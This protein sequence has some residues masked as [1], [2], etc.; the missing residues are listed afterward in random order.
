MSLARAL[1]VTIVLTLILGLVAYGQTIVSERLA[2]YAGKTA[3][4]TADKQ[5]N[6]YADLFRD[7][8][9]KIPVIA[10]TIMAPI[11]VARALTS[12]R[13]LLGTIKV[14]DLNKHLLLFGPTGSGKTSTALRAVELALKEGVSVEVLDWK[15]EYID[16]IRGATV[17][18]KMRLLEPPKEVDVETHTMVVVDILKDV[19]ELTE[20]MA[21]MLFE[22][23]SRMYEEGEQSFKALLERLKK[24]RAVALANRYQAEA[25]IAEGLIRR[26]LPLTLDEERRAVNLD[27]DG[28]VVIYDLSEL[29]TYHLKTLYSQIIMWRIYNEALKNKSNTLRK[30]V[31]MEEAQNYVRPRRMEAQPSIAERIVNELRAYG[32]GCILISTNPQYLLHLS[33]NCGVVSIG[34]QALPEM[35]TNLLSYYRYT[36]VKRLIKTTSK[37]Y[38]YIYYNGRL[39]VKNPPKP[40]K[41]I[42]DLNAEARVVEVEE[43]PPE[44][45]PQVLRVEEEVEVPEEPALKAEGGVEVEEAPEVAAPVR[46]SG[47]DDPGWGIQHNDTSLRCV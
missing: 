4:K 17:V 23:I 18:R 33:R 30:L 21:Y 40:Y 42:I 44:T 26:I 29:P 47:L 14:E 37:T 38:T 7:L 2:K 35:I 36:D 12:R 19:L 9:L 28:R 32:Y 15:G 39:Y 5:V 46:P 8:S 20:P 16:K 43:R 3:T 27:G 41:Y 1:A 31:I 22:E 45:V 6:Q 24:R 11:M 10:A 25:N 34:Y 13:R